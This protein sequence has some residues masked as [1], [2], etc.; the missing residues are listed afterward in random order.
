MGLMR[1]RADCP[2]TGAGATGIDARART[3]RSEK[4]SAPKVL[5]Q[6]LTARND[7]V[8]EDGR[9]GVIERGQVRKK[10]H[11]KY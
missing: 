4:P 2:G 7:F 9:C 11:L 1:G 10:V 6:P 5:P 3:P 8:D